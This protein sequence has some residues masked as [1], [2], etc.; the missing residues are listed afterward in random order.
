MADP[1]QDLTRNPSSPGLV[2]AG[3]RETRNNYMKIQSGDEIDSHCGKCK[4]E[5][6]H[7]VV[8][9][10]G[11]TVVKVVCKTCGHQHRHKSSEPLPRGK[12]P[13]SG[14]RRSIGGANR[15]TQRWEDA[16]QKRE[17]A[18]RKLYST[19]GSFEPGDVIEHNLFGCGVVT[20]IATGG[21]MNV[22]FREGA[23]RLVCNRVP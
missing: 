6:V 5:R 3:E 2:S 9:L 10:V 13:S 19:C 4:M 12:T 16:L 14:P 8:A 15:Q 20:E 21:K 7:H 22:L 17:T 18:V 1:L 23:R 11:G